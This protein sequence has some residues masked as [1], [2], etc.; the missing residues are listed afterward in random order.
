M[1]PF[2]NLGG[3]GLNGEAVDAITDDLTTDLSRVP[4]FLVIARNSAF[5]YKGKPID[6][7]RV[8][9][10]LGVRYAVE[11]SVRKVDGTLRVNVQL[12][13]TET[14]THLWAE[15]FDVRRDGVGYGVDDIVRQIAFALSGRIVDTEAAR[16]LRERPANPDVA[17]I[18]LR[19]R[20]VYNRPPTPQRQDELVALYE[21][22]IELDPNS[23]AA[24]AGLAEALLDGFAN[25]EDPTNPEKMRRAEELIKRAEL[26][27]PDDMMVMWTRV[28]LLGWQDR[29]PELMVAAQRAVEVHP[30]LTGPR[31][32]RGICLM[33]MGRPAEAIPELEQAI[34]INPR[35]PGIET[36]VS[37]HG[38]R[39][40]VQR[41]IR[42][43]DRLVSKSPGGKSQR[44]RVASQHPS[45]PQSPV[46]RRSQ[47]IPNRRGR[48]PPRPAG[49][50]RRLPCEVSSRSTSSNRAQ[51]RRS[52]GCTTGCGWPA[53]AITPMKTRISAWRR[54]V[55]STPIT[56][57]RRPPPCQE[58]RPFERRTWLGS[59]N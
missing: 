37:L 22:A 39:I 28:Y 36:P 42:R 18:L 56:R 33:R 7:K 4:S 10:E 1:L 3:D 47:A 41:A 54:T 2:S 40:A 32:W 15:R 24:L 53:F 25:V 49:S 43:S 29:C 31:Q 21:R 46:P 58:H 19:A 12:V 35:N 5:T 44:T 16:N 27:R 57:R 23:A 17:D 13:A 9:E 52:P 59:W 48:V 51:K 34:R 8:G 55:S 26:L 6:V 45:S 30:T 50:G 14:G 38:L 20:S 11:G